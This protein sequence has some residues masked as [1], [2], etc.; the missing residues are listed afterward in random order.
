MRFVEP[1]S[2]QAADD[3]DGQLR[4]FFRSQMPQPWPKPRLSRSAVTSPAPRSFSGRPLMR[5]RWALAASIGLLLLGSSLLPNRFTNDVKPE[6]GINGSTISDRKI[7][8][9]ARKGTK[10]NAVEPGN[11]VGLGAD[12]VDLFP[13]VD[14]ADMPFM[15]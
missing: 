7:L 10:G 13:E 6:Q 4:A 8:P 9:D 12:P 11:K 3:L 5:S 2:Q 15:K 14:E 1:L